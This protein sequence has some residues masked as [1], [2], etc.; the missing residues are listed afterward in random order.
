MRLLNHVHT[1]L[2]M[3]CCLLL[4]ACTV[5][6]QYPDVIENKP[7]FLSDSYVLSDVPYFQSSGH[8]GAGPVTSLLAINDLTVVPSEIAPMLYEQESPSGFQTD[9]RTTI[10]AFG[11]IPYPMAPNLMALIVEVASGNTVLVLLSGAERRNNWQ[12]ALVKGYDLAGETMV[13]N[14]GDTENLRLPLR[15]FERRWMEANRQAVMAVE[16]GELPTT[17]DAADYFAALAAL[18][19]IDATDPDLEAAY[20]AGL[21][22]WPDDRNLLMGFG[23][24]LMARG[25]YFQAADVFSETM[26]LYPEYGMAHNNMARALIELGRLGEA[27]YH[28]NQAI[29]IDDEFNEVYMETLELINSRQ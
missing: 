12:Y 6:Y 27:R 23:D 14:S 13:V 25:Q 16:P 7:D 28:A 2:A 19:R 20:Q 3:S 9:L 21:E 26:N 4:G 24:Y 8:P 17:A 1:A 29:D 11:Q 15:D 5:N 10:R 22:Q 18:Q